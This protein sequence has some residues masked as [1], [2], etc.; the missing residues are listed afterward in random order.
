MSTEDVQNN[1]FVWHDG[2]F[3]VKE[4]DGTYDKD[5]EDVTKSDFRL[6]GDIVKLDRVQHLVFGWASIVTVD[7][8][9]ICDTQGDIISSMTMEDAAYDFV[10]TARKGGEMHETGA[11]G[12]ARGVSRLVESIAFTR[13]KQIAMLS[14][15]HEQGITNAMVDLGCE[16]WWVGFYIDNPGTWSRIESGELKAFS[17]GGKGKRDDSSDLVQRFAS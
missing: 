12:T 16:G 13:E 7:G 1:R 5:D 6:V 8:K 17:I 10:L 11:D 15:L 2:D 9:E 4:D 14:S 3:E